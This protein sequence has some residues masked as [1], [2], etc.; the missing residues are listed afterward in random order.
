VAET[1]EGHLQVDR[2]ARPQTVEEVQDAGTMDVPAELAELERRHRR[3]VWPLTGCYLGYYLLLIVLA[4]YAPGLMRARIAG[5]LTFAYVFALSQF[6]MV[7]VAAYA[8]V[9]LARTEIDPLV[10]RVRG[11]LEEPTARKAPR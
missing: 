4:G 2:S 11:R 7:G 8:Y 5:E 1:L 10:E 6:P 3:L 9:R